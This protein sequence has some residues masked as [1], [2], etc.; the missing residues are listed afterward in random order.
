MA[1][2]RTLLAKGVR[3]KTGASKAASTAGGLEPL[4][5]LVGP[6]ADR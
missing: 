1:S 2:A 4:G 5:T 3:R 6:V